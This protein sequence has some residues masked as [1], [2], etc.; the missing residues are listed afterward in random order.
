MD[1]GFK[2]SKVKP[3]KFEKIK[4]AKIYQTKM[5]DRTS[6]PAEKRKIKEEQGFKC[7]KCGK[8]T[9]PR[10]LEV[11]HKKEIH[12]HK[13]P[14]GYDLPV[15]TI[16]TKY[17]PKYDRRKNLEAVCIKCHDKTKKRRKMKNP[18]DMRGLI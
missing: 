3:L 10:F 5:G 11:H 9:D 16:G 13:S 17:K 6:T 18:L 14:Y 8:K 15:M 4:I 7:A 1:F 2:Q 12:K